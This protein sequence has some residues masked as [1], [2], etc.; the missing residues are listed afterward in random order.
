MHSSGVSSLSSSSSPSSVFSS[1]N[2]YSVFTFVQLLLIII[3]NPFPDFIISSGE[4]YISQFHSPL[5]DNTSV[6]SRC[7]SINLP[8]ESTG[9]FGPVHDFIILL[10]QFSCILID[11]NYIRVAAQLFSFFF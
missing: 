10:L 7:V 4:S 5:F 2:Q 9:A 1:T 8:E 6:F 11:F 3:G